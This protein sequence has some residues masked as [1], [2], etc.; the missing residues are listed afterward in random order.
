MSPF[1]YDMAVRWNLLLSAWHLARGSTA[2]ISWHLCGRDATKKSVTA[3][4]YFEFCHESLF[5][6]TSHAC[7]CWHFS[8][9]VRLGRGCSW[10][11]NHGRNSIKT[12]FHWNP[13]CGLSHCMSAQ[14]LV[15]VWWS[16]LQRLTPRI[17]PITNYKNHCGTV[18]HEKFFTSSQSNI[19]LSHLQSSTYS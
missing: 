16:Q 8:C 18:E 6:T 7:Q 19:H 9:C 17:Q 10:R 11:L 15:S 13:F 3:S 5:L 14:A 4:P 1:G 2:G 12:V